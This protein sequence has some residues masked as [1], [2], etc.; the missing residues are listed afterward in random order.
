M[1]GGGRSTSS[2]TVN[3]YVNEDIK[4]VHNNEKNIDN[5]YKQHDIN[6]NIQIG[7]RAMGGIVD[8]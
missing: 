3:N 5:Y 4:N 6:T 8:I 1:G 7:D 2:K